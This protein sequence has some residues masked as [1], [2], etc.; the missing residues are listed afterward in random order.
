MLNRSERRPYK[1]KVRGSSPRVSIPQSQHT[2]KDA[3]TDV[4]SVM[5]NNSGS[6][7]LS[8]NSM[9]GKL[10]SSLIGKSDIEM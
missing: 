7:W 9:W 8:A 5:E 6:D 1:P 2:R 3:Y 10:S 4:A